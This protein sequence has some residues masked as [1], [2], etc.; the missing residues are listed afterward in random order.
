MVAEL[1]L[2][3]YL[4]AEHL[5]VLRAMPADLLD[6]RDIPA[7]RQ[8]FEAALEAMPA[9]ELP[10]EVA[11]SEELVPGHDPEDPPVRIKIYRPEGLAAGAAALY[12]IHGGGMVMGSADQ[13]DSRCAVW[14]AALGALVVSV[15]Y[16]LAPEDPY[17]APL[18]DC[19]AG[20][21]WLASSS[22]DLGVDPDLIAIGGASAGGG[23]AAGL[24]LRARDAGG[25]AICY[26]HLV[27]PMI[28]DRNDTHS[29][30]AIT[31]PR[32]W[33]REANRLGWAA[34]LGQSGQGG[35]V[36]IYAAPARATNLKGLPPAY[37]PVGSLDLFLDENIDY[38]QRMLQAGVPVELRVY[39]GAFHGSNGFAS[40]TAISRRWIKDE[41]DAARRGLGG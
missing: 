20:L 32:V 5:S 21:V 14:A 10:P 11:I 19:Y 24:A 13:D 33:N 1:D 26:Q 7:A 9:V 15:D 8:R 18:D 3:N 23:L 2:T 30:H 28:D 25:P 38:A 40:R 34:Y 36:P 16:R 4:D 41:L 22:S 35:E 17:P 29:S 39:P 31:D 6:L 37:L 27:Y 12:W